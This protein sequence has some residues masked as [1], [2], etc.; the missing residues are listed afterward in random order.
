[1]IAAGFSI[2]HVVAAVD[3]LPQSASADTAPPREAT[4]ALLD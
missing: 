3:L 1:M 4:G 2:L